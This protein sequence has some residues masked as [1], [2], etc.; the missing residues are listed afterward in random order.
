MKVSL[1]MENGNVYMFKYKIPNS[2]DWL[3]G[4]N[5]VQP[6]NINEINGSKYW[7]NMTD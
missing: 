5:G 3:I 7:I 6:E 1:K 4:I 2:S